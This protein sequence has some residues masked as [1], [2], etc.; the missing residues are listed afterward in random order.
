MLDGSR[1]GPKNKQEIEVKEVTILL[2][3]AIQTDRKIKS[4]KPDIVV[5]DYKRKTF[6]L[7][8]ICQ[9]IITY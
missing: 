8:D 6:F 7:I 3:F 2:D 1:T 4:N 5:K 9:Q